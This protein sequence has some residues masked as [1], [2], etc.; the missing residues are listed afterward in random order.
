MCVW[1][2]T[3]A[4]HTDTQIPRTCTQCT[5]TQTSTHIHTHTHT[6]THTSKGQWEVQVTAW[7]VPGPS[8]AHAALEGEDGKA[9]LGVV[10]AV[11]VS[12]DGGQRWHPADA[13]EPAAAY[14]APA[15]PGAVTQWAFVCECPPVCPRLHYRLLTLCPAAY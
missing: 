10:A 1:R 15:P 13:L 4:S 3:H 11:E 2:H 7:D 12:L 14:L 8:A 6:H 5:R 9:T